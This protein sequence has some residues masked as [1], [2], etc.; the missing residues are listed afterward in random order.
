MVSVGISRGLSRAMNWSELYRRVV[1]PHGREV[2][3]G[4]GLLRPPLLQ[5]L[6]DLHEMTGQRIP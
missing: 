2:D 4:L 6:G 1:D 5:K 3:A